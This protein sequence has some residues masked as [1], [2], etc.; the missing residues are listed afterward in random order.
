MINDYDLIF[1]AETWYINQQEY[2][3]HS[4]TLAS[5]SPSHVYTED[6]QHHGLLC[7]YSL[8]LRSFIFQVHTSEFSISIST[9]RLTVLTVYLPPTFS[10][11]LF[12][13]TLQS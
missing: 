12:T 4:L 2:L 5:T 9:P 1:L 6:R 11:P 8:L 7:L 13:Q 3:K 10:S